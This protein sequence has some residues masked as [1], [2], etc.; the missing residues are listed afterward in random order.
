MFFRFSCLWTKLFNYK[1]KYYLWH[2]AT[3]DILNVLRVFQVKNE[4]L[5]DVGGG[6]LANVL[7]VQFLFFKRKLDLR[8]DQT[9]C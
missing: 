5:S 9:S 3:C 7:E 2:G 8:H 6:R 4:M 1:Y